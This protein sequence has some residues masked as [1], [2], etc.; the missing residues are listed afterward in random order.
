MKKLHFKIFALYM[1]LLVNSAFSQEKKDTVLLLSGESIS[2]KVVRIDDEN[3]VMKESENVV[4]EFNIDRERV[5]SYTTSSGEKVLYTYDTLAGNYFTVQDMRYFIR[6]EQD[7]KRGF[8]AKPAFYTNMLI[9]AAGGITGSFFFPIPAFTFAI[10]VGIPKVKINKNTVRRQEDLDHIP[11]I[12]G[13]ERMARRNR[14]IQALVGGGIGIVAGLGTFLI[15]QGSDKQ[16]I[17]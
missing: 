10:L 17:K 13:Y 11:Y 6:G 15:L 9:G 7:G 1:I 16:L 3:L 2:G 14:K 8:R 12:M 4:R 5:F